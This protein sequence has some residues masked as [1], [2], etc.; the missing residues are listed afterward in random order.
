MKTKIGLSILFLI[1]MAGSVRT[2]QSQGIV[3]TM[4]KI[5]KRFIV[6]SIISYIDPEYVTDLKGKPTAP[7]EPIYRPIIKPE[8]DPIKSQKED[9]KLGRIREQT[10]RWAEY[11][12]IVREKV[13]AVAKAAHAIA[14]KTIEY[15]L[16]A[17]N[18]VRQVIFRFIKVSVATIYDIAFKDMLAA[19]FNSIDLR[20]IWTLVVILKSGMEI[21]GKGMQMVLSFATT[22]PQVFALTIAAL[23]VF[24]IYKG[25]YRWF[26]VKG[27]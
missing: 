11:A 4:L 15:L 17:V 25:L 14:I 22:F 20:W 9:K 19:V 18:K 12:R 5:G 10:N 8:V 27:H 7:K 13:V 24:R 26:T 23:I 6:D 21:L 3:E 2:G 1:L 16:E